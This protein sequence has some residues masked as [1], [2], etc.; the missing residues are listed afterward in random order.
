MELLDPNLSSKN[1]NDDDEDINVDFNLYFSEF[2][3]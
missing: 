1:N 3:I 2:D